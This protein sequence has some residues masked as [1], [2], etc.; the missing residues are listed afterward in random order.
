[1]NIVLFYSDQLSSH[2]ETTFLSLQSSSVQPLLKVAF[3]FVQKGHIAV[4]KY[5]FGLLRHD[6]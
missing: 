3:N 5:I 4:Y 2:P 6:K 1:M